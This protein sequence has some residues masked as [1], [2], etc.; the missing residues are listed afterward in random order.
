[1]RRSLLLEGRSE[2]ARGAS[3]AAFPAAA[4]RQELPRE[5]VSGGPDTEPPGGVQGATA[6]PVPAMQ[7]LIPQRRVSTEPPE[8]APTPGAA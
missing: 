1:M 5:V 8:A 3:Q 7:A 2:K 4:V 6:L